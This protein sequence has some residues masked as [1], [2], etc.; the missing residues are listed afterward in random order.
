MLTALTSAQFICAAEPAPFSI[1]SSHKN[2]CDNGDENACVQYAMDVFLALEKYD[3]Q[4]VERDQTYAL[5]LAQ[6]TDLSSACTK[7]SATGCALSAMGTAIKQ[8]DVR[9]KD[10]NTVGP[11]FSTETIQALTKNLVAECEKNSALACLVS[12]MILK[13]KGTDIEA[14]KN[15]ALIVKALSLGD[16]GCRGGDTRICQFLGRLYLDK[17]VVENGGLQAENYYNIAIKYECSTPLTCFE[18]GKKQRD[19]PN[20]TSR[21]IDHNQY[22]VDAYF[23]RA[24]EDGEIKACTNLGWSYKKSFYGDDESTDRSMPLFNKACEGGDG[25]GCLNIGLIYLVQNEKITLTQ[26]SVTMFIKACSDPNVRRACF[27]VGEAYYSGVGAPKNR[28]LAKTY[29]LRSCADKD[30]E[31]LRLIERTGRA[32]TKSIDQVIGDPWH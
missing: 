32:K 2:Q 23:R 28:S 24:C 7:G 31:C 4:T 11:E 30:Q 19:L 3:T 5:S 14:D 21:N 6:S 20:Y 10:P 8:I 1:N 13:D 22:M 27:I 25:L 15:Q 26:R 29:Y 12:G 17:N 18:M 16:A 9:A